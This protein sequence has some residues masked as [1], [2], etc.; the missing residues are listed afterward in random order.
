M[1]SSLVES[2]GDLPV[3]LVLLVNTGVLVCGVVVSEKTEL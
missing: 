2:L 1:R 3:E